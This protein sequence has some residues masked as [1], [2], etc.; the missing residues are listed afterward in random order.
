ML[1]NLVAK[2][3]PGEF[4]DPG[5]AWVQT[6]AFA[7]HRLVLGFVV[8]VDGSASRMRSEIANECRDFHPIAFHDGTRRRRRVDVQDGE[9]GRGRLKFDGE[10]MRGQRFCAD[11]NA[12]LM[13]PWLVT[14]RAP[15]ELSRSSRTGS[16]SGPAGF[17]LLVWRWE[18]Q[19]HRDAGGCRAVVAYFDSYRDRVADDGRL[20]FY[21]YGRYAGGDHGCGEEEMQLC[22]GVSSGGIVGRHQGGHQCMNAWFV[23]AGFPYE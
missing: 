1:S 20:W 16:N 2:G 22:G 5:F 17:G 11:V 8:Q 3:F 9:V 7:V 23:I 12:E 13:R 19:R 10:E 4:D 14:G 21:G 15:G 18:M 6:D